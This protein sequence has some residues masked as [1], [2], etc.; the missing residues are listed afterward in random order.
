MLFTQGAV[1]SHM[2]L[3]SP[4]SSGFL[5]WTL[6]STDGI[7]IYED[8]FGLLLCL[9]STCSKKKLF[10]LPANLLSRLMAWNKT[11]RK[12]LANINFWRLIRI[13]YDLAGFSVAYIAFVLPTIHESIKTQP[14]NAWICDLTFELLGAKYVSK[15]L[16]LCKSNRIRI[17]Q[18]KFVFPMT[19]IG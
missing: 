5:L 16:F 6:L 11:S 12:D 18:R 3:D 8:S 10:S 17:F 19:V 2:S 14:I 4:E 9:Y 7:F 15:N 13:F 1:Q